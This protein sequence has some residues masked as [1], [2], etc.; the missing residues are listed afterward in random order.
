[1]GA[2]VLRD[3]LKK[4]GVTGVTVE[5]KAIAN[6]DSKADVVIT[7]QQLTARAREKAPKAQHVSVDNFMGSPAYDE[8][9]NLVKS[10]Q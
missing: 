3:K 8:V 1:M 5:N 7:Q 4:A 9:V 2:T 6:L 10:Q